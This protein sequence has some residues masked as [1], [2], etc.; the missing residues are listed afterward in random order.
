MFQLTAK[1]KSKLTENSFYYIRTGEDEFEIC[2]HKPG[3]SAKSTK[4]AAL[5]G[6]TF[7]ITEQE[8]VERLESAVSRDEEIR[9]QYVGS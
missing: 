8:E 4:H 5:P 9:K 6:F 7:P 2:E 3:D 1:S